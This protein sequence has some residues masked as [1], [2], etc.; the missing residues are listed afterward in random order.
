MEIRRLDGSQGDGD[1]ALD[2]LLALLKTAVKHPV[3]RWRA[4]LVCAGAACGTGLVR[5]DDLLAAIAEQDIRFRRPDDARRAL[6]LALTVRQELRGLLA[7]G[8]GLLTGDEPRREHFGG[9]L[10]EA[11]LGFADGLDLAEVD[12]DALPPDA[13]VAFRRLGQ[14]AA[15]LAEGDHPATQPKARAGDREAARVA[16]EQD[17]AV[18]AQALRG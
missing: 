2:E 8:G 16:V 10:S 12:P 17:V 4:T 14:L 18:I 11:L 7:A 3:H 5:G 9:T 6:E 1:K 13:A 15:E